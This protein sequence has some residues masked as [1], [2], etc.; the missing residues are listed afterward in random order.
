MKRKQGESSP[1]PVDPQYGRWVAT[2]ELLRE[3]GFLVLSEKAVELVAWSHGVSVR[4]LGPVPLS[5]AVVTKLWGAFQRGLESAGLEGPGRSGNEGSFDVLREK[6]LELTCWQLGSGIRSL[7][8]LPRSGHLSQEA[9]EL[10][11]DSFCRGLQL[12]GRPS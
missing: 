9:V 3:E 6:A 2:P 1:P 12:Q 5:E 7:G 11:V 10:R 4:N 8:S